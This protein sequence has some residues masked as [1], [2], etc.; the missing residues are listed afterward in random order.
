MHAS[1]LYFSGRLREKL[2]QAAQTRGLVIEAPSGYG[3]TTAV[4]NYLRKILPKG[5][6]WIRHV[7]AGESAPAAW[8]R[9]AQALRRI[10]P[11]TGDAL[12]ALG[13]PDK[14]TVGDAET[15]LREMN[16]RTSTW[17][18]IDDF[19]QIAPLAPLSLWRA[20]LEHEARRLRV[21]FV[22][23]PLDEG[24][25]RYE[26]GG[27]FTSMK[28]T[29]AFPS[30]NA[31]NFSPRPA[32]RSPRRER[33]SSTAAPAAGSSPLSCISS[34]MSGTANSFQ[35]PPSTSCCATLSGTS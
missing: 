30:A 26:K 33:M 19:H 29:C 2:D 25:M 27:F 22:T 14:D 35:P 21:V 28:T 34:T 10:D 9:F 8:R 24:L 7:C 20:L 31:A 18:V 16:C 6:N 13:L 15:L 5:T 11:S 32:F 17:L 1:E 4:Q 12:L 3:K 23:R